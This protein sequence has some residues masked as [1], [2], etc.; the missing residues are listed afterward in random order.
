MFEVLLGYENSAL[1]PA[2][3]QFTHCV[4]SVEYSL[5]ARFHWVRK[6]AV[7]AFQKEPLQT[8][9]PSQKSGLG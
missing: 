2:P 1:E 8:L 6:L 7:I 9:E 5:S 3:S 4:P